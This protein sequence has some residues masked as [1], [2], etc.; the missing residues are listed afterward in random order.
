[1]CGIVAIVGEPRDQRWL[2]PMI[3]SLAARGPDEDGA[4]HGDW[5]GLGFRRLAI[6]A[7]ETGHQPVSSPSGD[8]TL[9]FNGELYDYDAIARTLRRTHGVV[10]RCEAD[11]LLALYLSRGVDFTARLNGD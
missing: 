8:V 4:V 1:V 5:F 7:T 11:A 6:F 2:A 9:A 3:A 10:V